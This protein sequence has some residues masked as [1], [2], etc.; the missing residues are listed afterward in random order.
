MQLLKPDESCMLYLLPSGGDID[1]ASKTLIGLVTDE[2][3]S[4]NTRL[5]IA[6]SHVKQEYKAPYS[7]K[8]RQTRIQGSL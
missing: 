2:S 4:K 1:A 7:C 6:V 8:S 3:S 5:L